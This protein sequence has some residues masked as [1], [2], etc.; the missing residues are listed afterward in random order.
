[1]YIYSLCVSMEP[2][3]LVELPVV[4]VCLHVVV[5]VGVDML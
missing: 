2:P 1:M 5:K 4:T 3:L